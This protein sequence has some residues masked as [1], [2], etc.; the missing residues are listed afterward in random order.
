MRLIEGQIEKAITLLTLAQQSDPEA[1]PLNE[2]KV[3]MILTDRVH[4]PKTFIAVNRDVTAIIMLIVAD[5]W[6]STK[7]IIDE[8]VFFSTTQGSGF[9]LLKEAKKWVEG[10]GDSIGCA[11]F[12]TTTENEKV[13]NMLERF[14]L[15][16]VGTKF[17][18]NRGEG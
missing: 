14:G 1:S 12:S 8:V 2:E 16:K 15:Q 4:D 10:W 18:F 5:D 3:R 11:Y 7:P 6:F 13:D 9:R 17:K